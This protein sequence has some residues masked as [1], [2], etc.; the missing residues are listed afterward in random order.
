MEKNTIILYIFLTL[1]VGILLFT[2][3]DIISNN[4]NYINKSRISK[5]VNN[6]SNNRSNNINNLDRVN[7]EKNAMKLQNDKVFNDIS[8]PGIDEVY[9]DIFKAK[10]EPGIDEVYTDIFKAK[11]EPVIDKVYNDISE[12]DIDEVYTDISKPEIDQNIDQSSF[13]SMSIENTFPTNKT[14]IDPN[15]SELIS[16]SNSMIDFHKPKKLRIRS[17]TIFTKNPRHEDYAPLED[18]LFLSKYESNYINQPDFPENTS[19]MLPNFNG[20]NVAQL[21]P[22]DNITK[23]YDTINSDIY[24]GYKTYEII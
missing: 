12:P 2:F 15:Y 3:V 10:S 8:E 23:L 21:F 20:D 5:M 9:T 19:T 4:T 18:T 17:D 14:E 22:V 16:M 7:N 24:K 11:S 6:K 1:G 13:F